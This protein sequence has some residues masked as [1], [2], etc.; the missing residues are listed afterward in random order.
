MPCTPERVWKAIHAQ[1]GAESGGGAT[2]GAAA[3][4]FDASATTGPPT[5]TDGGAGSDP[6]PVRLPRARPRVEEA[7]AAL[8]EH[9]DDAKIIA[10]GQSLLPVLRMR[11]N[12]PEVVIDLGRIEALRGIRDDGDAIVIG[13]MTTHADVLHDAL[14]ARARAR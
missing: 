13:A 1:D 8:A 12:A 3:P 9:G 6:R 4:H 5:A 14:V 7:L 2:E 11:L 10:G